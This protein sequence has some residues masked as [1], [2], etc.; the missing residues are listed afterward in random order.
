MKRLTPLFVA[1]SLGLTPTLFSSLASAEQLLL[2]EVVVTARKREEPLQEVPVAVS[3]FSSEAVESLGIRNMRDIDGLVPGL[4]LGGGGNGL[5]GDGNAYIRGV[6]QRETRVTVDS[7]VGIY[8]DDIYIARS[9]GALLD[10]VDIESVQVL[11]GPQGTLFGK[12]TTGGAILYQ[13]KK[14]T[15]DF[16]ADARITLGN[17]DK[18]D[19]SLAV[20]APLIDNK[21]LSRWTIAGVQQD[22]YAHNGI[23]DSD[24]SDNNRQIAIGQ[25]RWLPSDSVSVDFNFNYT[26]TRQQPQ[27]HKC[28]WL[29][30]ELEA[31]GFTDTGSLE[32]I[33]D[34][35]S[36]E[37][38]EESCKR[39][40]ENL[41]VDE[42]LSEQNSLNGV[43]YEASYNVDT[44]MAATTVYWEISDA[45]Q[46]K[47]IT[48]YRNTQQEADEDIDGMDIVVT[49]RYGVKP[50]NTDQY[51]QEFQFIGNA[52]DE[53]LNYTL[54]LYAFFEETDDDWLQDFAGFVPQTIN[55][56][57]NTLL[58]RSLLHERETENTSY[59]AFGQLD[60]DI[61][62][63]VILTLGLRY[64]W[65][66]RKTAYREG[67]VYLPSIG[68][69]DYSGPDTIYGANIL[70][71]FSEPGVNPITE[72]QYGFDPDGLP[73]PN[74]PPGYVDQPFVVGAFGEDSDKRD[75]DDWNPMASIK[76]LASD[77]VLDALGLDSGMA[78]LTYATGFR[79]GGVTV[80]N[81]DFDGD[82]IIDLENFK[83]E[84]VDMIEIGFKVDAFDRKLRANVAAYYQE[85]DDIQLTTTIP[86]PSFGVPLP[87]IENAGKA[88][89]SGVEAEFTILPTDALRFRGSIAY[90]DAEFKEW[91]SDVPANQL[92]AD[93]RQG[94]SGNTL[95]EV[96]RA[97]EPMP[98]APE[99][100]AF[101]STEYVFDTDWGTIT[102][103]LIIRYSDEIYGGFDRLSFYVQEDVNAPEETFYDA[104]INWQLNDERTSFVFWVKNLADNDDHLRGGVP[105]VGVAR[106]SGRTYWPPRTYGIDFSYHFGD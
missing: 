103:N 62:E 70:H 54:G 47:S 98:R 15:E 85:Y 75:D 48:A 79:S 80:G 23:D 73:P 82:Q 33:L 19:L 7:G 1:T 22:G 14:P 10:A 49:G 18:R 55:P 46:L 81:G 60:F 61:T 27:A 20:N 105:T 44:A 52:F 9:S 101:L 65:E 13:S 92:P 2:E 99:W 3:A 84:F 57:N 77:S 38:V 89:I 88:E 34:L 90:I 45:I 24:W 11:R 36:S 83:P 93:Q 86:D 12:N 4:H 78:Y 104:R 6:G 71:T 30:D 102:P 5:K 74:A 66:E 21:L 37:T 29:G 43:F 25:L 58:A 8:L 59:A 51:S 64:T 91:L 26:R 69:G 50:N 97:D 63:S 100:T 76:Y 94:A 35:F 16:S 72:W 67:R 56:G 87:A 39:S 17:L 31:A 42:F 40:G 95:V 32:G 41:P 96:S 106:T 28:N 53:K 68:N